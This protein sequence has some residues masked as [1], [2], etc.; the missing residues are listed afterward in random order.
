[1]SVF[2][3]L[4]HIKDI[5]PCVEKPFRYIGGEAGVCK[6]E[7]NDADVRICLAFPD[8]Y[9]MGMSNIGLSILYHIVNSRPDMLAERLFAPWPD[10]EAELVRRNMPLFSIESKRPVGEF[11][12]LGIAV[13]YELSYTNI[14]TILSLGKI[15]LRSSDRNDS[16]PL[17]IA[18]GPCAF[19]PEPVA[20][21]FDAIVL[22][23][24]EQSLIEIM[25][26]VKACKKECVQKTRLLPRLSEIEGVYVPSLG[27]GRSVKKAIIAD[28]EEAPYPVGPVI[29]YAA[30]HDRAGIEVSR[31]CARGCRFCQ[32]GF[33]YRPVRH[34]SL[35]TSLQ[36][37][38]AQLRNSGHEDYSFLSLSLGDY[39]CLDNLLKFVGESWT[40][41]PVN[42]QLPSLR[43]ES[44]SDE[45]LGFLGKARSG[46]FTLAPEAATERMRK[47]INK[48]NSDED[49][50]AS[51]EKI[52]SAGW[53]QIKLYF[54]IGLTGETQDEL[55][56][57]VVMANRCLDIGKRYHKRA[58]VTVS[59]STFVPKP[60]TPLQWAGQISIEET[61]EKQSYLKKHLRR[62]GLFYKWHDARMSFLEGVFS[63]GD[64]G[65]C[66]VIEQAHRLG[67]R[68]DAWDEYF[69][70]SLW[71]RA[72]A[73]ANM[74]PG[75]YLSGRNREDE[76]PWDHL[77]TDLKKSFLWKEYERS[78][79]GL[80]TPDCTRD[81]CQGCGVCK[82]GRL[83][84]QGGQG[85]GGTIPPLCKGRL[86]GVDHYL[87]PPTPPLRLCS[88]QA[89]K[90]GEIHKY[91]IKLNKTGPA[92]FL[93]H[94]EFMNV[95]R[96]A[97]RRAGL[98]LRYSE[99]FHP[100]ARVSFGKA[101]PIGIESECEF[102][103]VELSEPMEPSII[104]ERLISLF[105]E[106]VNIVSAEG[107]LNGVH[108]IEQ[109]IAAI[110]YEIY[111]PPLCKG[112]LGGVD[113]DL[114]PPPLPFD[115]AQ[116]R[117]TKEGLISNFNT[118]AAWPF[119][120][121]R[122]EKTTNV[123]L[124]QY[125]SRLVVDD[126]G[127]IGL[128]LNEREPMIRVSEVLEAIFKFND[129]E[130]KDLIIRKIGVLWKKKS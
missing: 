23:D 2:H 85:A 29:P 97:L 3:M 70:F 90:G 79:E 18:G 21:F 91:R 100:R 49:L 14:L 24:G 84:G 106:G 35:D 51:V 52:F 115:S 44:L 98:P 121:Q 80:L 73:A 62:H 11:D 66:A 68:F 83:S 61:L 25:E 10:M 6:K 45:T 31:G 7:W 110:N 27:K 5:L 41:S 77:Y 72:F 54:M 58:E 53:H 40:G 117:L 71:Q 17:I 67:A 128:T 109:S 81:K 87:P 50:Y 129:N 60:H 118:A 42:A 125:V 13:P 8:T 22:G 119:L 130:I 78:M 86:G 124:K 104:A 12:I 55:D 112:R 92:A 101:L 103:D 108:S 123:D 122:G 9:E 59:T 94:L 43:V 19:N 114:P 47:R 74:D 96:R 38:L 89:Y 99:G 76:F 26:A 15:P 82:T 33:I 46:S 37:A 34:R 127:V 57:I 1:L 113:H 102:C 30:V 56:G 107:L 95:I 120:R 75:S 69:D 36:L 64:R 16:H 88:G 4:A 93:G 105:S 126:K 111:F 32:A 28:L 39:P 20:D 65:L 63:R 116:G 48:G